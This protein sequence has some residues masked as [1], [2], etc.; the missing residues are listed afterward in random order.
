MENRPKIVDFRKSKIF[1]F[2]R[3]KADIKAIRLRIGGRF[4]PKIGFFGRFG[5]RIGWLAGPMVPI[6]GVSHL[7]QQVSVTWAPFGAQKVHKV[8]QLSEGPSLAVPGGLWHL[9]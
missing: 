2:R 5:S 4:Y 7:K 3:L 8:G 9:G 1:D 6:S